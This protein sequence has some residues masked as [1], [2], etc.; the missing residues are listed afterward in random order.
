MGET[1]SH[2]AATRGVPVSVRLLLGGEA[3]MGSCGWHGETS[4][5][6]AVRYQDAAHHAVSRGKAD[7]RAADKDPAPLVSTFRLPAELWL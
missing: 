3:W 2:R 7:M 6:T 5:F 1:E 4:L